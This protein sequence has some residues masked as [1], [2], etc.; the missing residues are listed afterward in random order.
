MDALWLL[1][2][3]VQLPETPARQPVFEKPRIAIG[4]DFGGAFGYTGE[5]GGPLLGAGVRATIPIGAR[6]AL[7]ARV[8]HV[9]PDM[10]GGM[11]EIRWQRSVDWPGA[12]DPDYAGAGL[13]GFYWME[14]R[15][16][17]VQPRI[18][19]ALKPQVLSLTAGWHRAPSRRLLV[20]IELTA[21]AHPYGAVGISLTIGTTWS[22]AI[23]AR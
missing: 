16:G 14:Y 4:A 19:G 20:P 6:S 7:T 5:G 15:R 22:P 17:R 18:A 13:V 1:L 8:M 10:S 9:V 2:A 11:Y 23:S 3:L 21:Y 12:F